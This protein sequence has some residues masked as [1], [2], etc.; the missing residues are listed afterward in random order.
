MEVLS[1]GI[2]VLDEALGGGLLEDSNLLI[3]YNTYSNGW[4]LAFEILRNR[5]GEGDFG[6]ILDHVLPLTPLK[7]KLG[8]L[9]F[10]V[11]KEGRAGN[12]AIVDVFSSF[13]KVDYGEDYVYTDSTLDSATFL[14]KYLH[15]YRRILKERIQ[16]RRPIGISATVDGLAFLL[17]E[18]STIKLFQSLMALKERARMEE[19]RKRPVNIFLLNRGRASDRLVSWIALYSQYVIEFCS[20]ADS[21][22][23]KMVIRKSPL[24]DFKPREGGYRFWIER[25]RVIIE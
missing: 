20:S 22:K 13:H 12:L 2:P 21:M 14:P 7:M 9:N 11:E 17:G 10:D 24:P 16:E 3:T 19:K 1:T 25:G 6:V 5:I 15:L 23:E 18:E 4:A 8:M